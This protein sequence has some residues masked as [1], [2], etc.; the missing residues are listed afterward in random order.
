[1]Y[2]GACAVL[3]ALYLFVPPLKGSA[4][5]MNALG[6]SPVVGILAGVRIHRPKSAAPWH[7]FA[8]GFTLFWLGDVYTYSYPKL[9]GGDVPFP[10][11][12]D[13]LYVLVY[14][15]LLAGLVL[16]IR[17]RNPR[18]D[19]PGTLDSI[20][21][22]VGLALFSWVGLIAPYLHDDSLTFLPKLVSVAYPMG[23]IVLLAA[24]IRLAVDAG[25]REASFRL[26][27][28]AMVALLLTDFGYGLA[29]LHGTYAHQL[30]YDAGWIAFYVLWG[31]A[32][33]HPSMRALDEPRA[34]RP[35]I[36]RRRLAML[37]SA[38]LIAP[39]LELVLHEDAG[40][41]DLRVIV[42]ASV[43]M[44]GFVVVRMA[45]LVAEVHRRSSDALLGALVQHGSDVITAL[46][47]DGVVVYQSPSIERA[48]GVPAAEMIGRRLIDIAAP[49]DQERLGMLLAIGPDESRIIE[50]ALAHRDGSQRVLEVQ[51]TNLLDDPDVGAIVLNSRDVT[52]RRAFERE[53]EHRAFH[54]PVTGLANR[55]LFL[56]RVRH[57]VARTRRT[58]QDF[59]VLFLDLDDF[60]TINDG[61]GHAAGDEVLAAVGERLSSAARAAD[62]VARFGGDEFAVLL[63]ESGGAQGAAD[64]SDRLLAALSVPL[65]VA[66]RELVLRA[67]VGVSIGGPGANADDVIRDAD[68][69]MYIAKRERSGGYRIF[70]PAMHDGVV[71]RLELRAD[72]ERA[73]AGGELELHYQPVVALGDGRPAGLEA[74]LRWH[75]PVRGL[76]GPD[77]FIPLAEETGLIVEIGRWVLLEACR[78]AAALQ[79]EIPADPPLG[80]SV[81]LSVVQLQRGDVAA[82]VRA[83]LTASG[84]D[85]A[86]LML[87]ITETA[88][89][90]DTGL[91]VERLHEIKALGVRLAMDDFGTGYSSL[92]YLSRLPVDVLKMDRSFLRDD[93]TAEE[94][95]LAAAVVALGRS[96]SLSV[97]AEGIEHADQ[98][99]S[100]RDLDCDLGQG[101]HFA[102]P[103]DAAATRQWLLE[104]SSSSASS[105]A[106]S[107]T[108]TPSFSALASLEPGDSP[109]TT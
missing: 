97:V 56:E 84:L 76:V 101:Y 105:P 47:R 38:T 14:P 32:A 61:L 81:N 89:M 93:V 49:A 66:H 35:R 90:S 18:F 64:A 79:R 43:A 16:L 65:H 54:D 92:S 25:R 13:A 87:E 104:R 107:S 73:I 48:L 29:T 4:P 80:M 19:A 75:H 100:L 52:E 34:E 30:S 82:D 86:L 50:F 9:F 44:F 95:G 10:S 60:K 88:T 77:E 74:L 23:D 85:P 51:Q 71:A 109:A 27:V 98:A 28:A 20:I 108:G 91:A 59:A 63:E 26:M 46:D 102:R 8:A 21:I 22:T 69:A 33:L 41:T 24:A 57:A 7:W 94:S 67:S 42:L 78:Q 39:V 99:S 36:T 40:A 12:G 103:M 2:L 83:A 53:L 58:G 106:S 62:V 3:L 72:L 6:L 96:L 1:M 55:A 31:A 17:R 15:A 45:G 5:V 68:A 70:E 37:T 11:P